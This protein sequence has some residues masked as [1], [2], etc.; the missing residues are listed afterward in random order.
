MRTAKLLCSGFIIPRSLERTRNL[1]VFW[2][3]RVA[4]LWPAYLVTLALVLV[5]VPLTMFAVPNAGTISTPLTVIEP[6]V[7]G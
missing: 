3:N 2:A 5:D 1:R 7:A 4:R 6:K